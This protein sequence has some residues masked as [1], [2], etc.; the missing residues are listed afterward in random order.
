MN[1]TLHNR[2]SAACL[3]VMFFGITALPLDALANR[4]GNRNVNRGNGNR[5]V[6]RN[7]NHGNDNRNV[8]R[9]VQS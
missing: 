2:I 9:N 6:N 7:V 8:N 5:N 4:N 1:H 3:A